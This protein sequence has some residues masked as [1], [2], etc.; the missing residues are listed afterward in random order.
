VNV[1]EVVEVFL[2][3]GGKDRAPVANIAIRNAELKFN[4]FID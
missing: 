3:L 2:E 4:L 1:V